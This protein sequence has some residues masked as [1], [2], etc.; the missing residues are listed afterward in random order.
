[1]KQGV[2]NSIECHFFTFKKNLKAKQSWR[3]GVEGGVRGGVRGDK[4]NTA[5]WL[6]A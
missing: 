4:S 6:Q 2:T 5:A 1:M 3:G